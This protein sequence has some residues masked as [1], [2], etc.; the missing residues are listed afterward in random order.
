MAR[1]KVMRLSAARKL[2]SRSDLYEGT[3]RVPRSWGAA[4]CNSVLGYCPHAGI[5]PGLGQ[6]FLH[7]KRWGAISGYGRRLSARRLAHS[8]EW[9]LEPAV[10]VAH[11]P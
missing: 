3:V 6:S 10:C 1:V 2:P 4:R 8:A 9:L 11:W 5:Y 7:G